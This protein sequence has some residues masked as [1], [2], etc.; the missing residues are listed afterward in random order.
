MTGPR[1]ILFD[2]NGVLVDEEE[3]WVA[4]FKNEAD[5]SNFDNEIF[6]LGVN[7]NQRWTE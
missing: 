5:R 7:S 6:D 1:G 3:L 2:F 4:Q